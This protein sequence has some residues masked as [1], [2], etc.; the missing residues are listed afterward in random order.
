MT[1]ARRKPLP[2]QRR[3]DTVSKAGPVFATKNQFEPGYSV[4]WASTHL[5]TAATMDEAVAIAEA[6]AKSGADN[7][8]GMRKAVGG[9]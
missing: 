6:V 9:I 8:W 2:E 4:C 7:I 3:F 1:I 5:A